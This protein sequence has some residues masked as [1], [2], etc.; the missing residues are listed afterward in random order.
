MLHEISARYSDQER[1]QTHR[2]ITGNSWEQVLV[3][4]NFNFFSKMDMIS[5]LSMEMLHCGAINEVIPVCV[6]YCGHLV[7]LIS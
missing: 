1:S 2:L 6:V 5:F 7:T 3:S 4:L